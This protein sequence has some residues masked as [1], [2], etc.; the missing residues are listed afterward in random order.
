MHKQ[1]AV[2]GEQL[3]KIDKSYW[4]ITRSLFSSLENQEREFAKLRE[5]YAEQLEK[6]IEENEKIKDELNGKK[7]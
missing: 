1:I 6:L 5:D 3:Q 4:D 2:L 7:K